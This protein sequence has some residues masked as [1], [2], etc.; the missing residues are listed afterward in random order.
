MMQEGA[1]AV[2]S[3]PSPFPMD[4]SDALCGAAKEHDEIRRLWLR[5][6]EQNGKTSF[7]AVIDGDNI[8]NSVINDL[9][10]AIKPFLKKYGLELN[11]MFFASE[12]GKKAAEN[13]L[14]VYTI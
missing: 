1:E 12:L 7:L 6:M 4:L 9:G 3:T 13:V 10:T 8:K 2:F 5:Q 14:P 11:V